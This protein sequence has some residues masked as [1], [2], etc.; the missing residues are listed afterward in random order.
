MNNKIQNQFSVYIIYPLVEHKN[1][2][3]KHILC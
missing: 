1:K 2:N 3:Q